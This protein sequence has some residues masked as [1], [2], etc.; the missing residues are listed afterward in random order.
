M[1]DSEQLN[2][3]STELDWAFQRTGSCGEALQSILLVCSRVDK[4]DRL[5]CDKMC[6]LVGEK[7]IY[8]LEV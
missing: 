3:P 7:V 8:L 1:T 2:V 5:I 4:S 6:D